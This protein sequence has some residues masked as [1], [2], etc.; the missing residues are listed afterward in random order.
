MPTALRVPLWSSFVAVDSN[1]NVEHANGKGNQVKS[2]EKGKLRN[3]LL[4]LSFI[5]STN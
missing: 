1:A 2:R 4:L 3:R 5:A